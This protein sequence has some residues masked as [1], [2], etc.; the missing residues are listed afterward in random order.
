MRNKTTRP[1]LTAEQRR[2]AERLTSRLT[3][4]ASFDALL[5]YYR[6]IGGYRANLRPTSP[7]LLA[8]WTDAERRAEVAER[9]LQL[10]LAML[11]DGT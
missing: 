4:F 1:K 8:R 10:Q 11:A 3:A 2:R 9:D 5:A 6:P 7:A